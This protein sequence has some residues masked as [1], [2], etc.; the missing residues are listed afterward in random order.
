MSLK[1]MNGTEP[2]DAVTSDGEGSSR[3]DTNKLYRSGTRRI[4]QRPYTY[5][6]YG[7]CK[8]LLLTRCLSRRPASAHEEIHN[9]PSHYTN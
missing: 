9:E 8:S 2:L 5:L 1:D 7:A 4:G 6:W 3:T